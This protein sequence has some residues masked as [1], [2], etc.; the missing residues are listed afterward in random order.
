MA[1]GFLGVTGFETTA[2]YVE[3][4]K[5]GMFKKTMKDMWGLVVFFN[6]VI[7]LMSLCVLDIPFIKAHPNDMLVYV[8]HKAGGEWLGKLIAI[9]AAIVLTGGV[10]TAYVAGIGVVK[11]L[12]LDR[13]LP[14]F[15]L[16]ENACRRTNHVMIAL[17]GLLCISLMAILDGD[18]HTLDLVLALSFLGVMVCA[19]TAACRSTRG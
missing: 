11:R 17:F 4:L 16:I 7:T 18:L 19:P 3:D 2:N 12:A 10:L 8:G 15:L 5:P 13:C 6:P 1:Q 9:D 14:Q